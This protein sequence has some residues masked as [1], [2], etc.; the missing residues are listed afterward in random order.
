M[1]AMKQILLHYL[2]PKQLSTVF[3]TDYIPG[4]MHEFLD[5]IYIKQTIRNLQ[6]YDIT[7]V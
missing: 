2:P 5:Y 4:G 3:S 7:S 6:I 1:N